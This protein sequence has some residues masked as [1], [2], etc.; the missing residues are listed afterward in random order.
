MLDKRLTEQRNP[1][2]RE[3]D[4][5]D[6][7]E[8]VD[9]MNAEDRTVPEAVALEREALA[10]AVELAVAAFR[11]GGRLIYVGAGTSGR[12]G[13]LDAAEMPPTFGTD[14]ELVPALLL[15]QSPDELHGSLALGL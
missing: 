3:I 1:R 12:L 7:L 11:G 10:R 15:L 5:L 9:L 13:V 6:P 2:S 14:P 4:R 8:I